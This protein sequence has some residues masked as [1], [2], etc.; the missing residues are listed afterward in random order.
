[1]SSEPLDFL[2]GDSMMAQAI[3]DQDWAMS[4][5][6]AADG[7]PDTLKTT[8]GLMLGSGF[9][10]AVVW[11][12]DLVTLYNDAFIPILGDKPAALGRSFQ[13]IWREAWTDI[14]PIAE[15]AFAGR[16]TYIE[17][18]PLVVERGRGPSQAYFTFC[19]SPVR[20]HQG[21]VLGFL[22][23]VTETTAT[24]IS[25]RRL[26]FLDQLS[27]NLADADDADT[28]MESTTRLLAEHLGVSNC[29]YADM[30]ADQDGFTIRGDWAAPG[31]PTIVG[32][33][34]LADFGR[35]AVK[36]LSAGEPLVIND[37][38]AELA[39]HE[40]ATFQ[41]IGIAATIC[42]P[43]VK[44]GR[45]TALMAI[46]DRKPRVWS[47]YECGLIAEVAQ[48]SWAHIER[49]R[50]AAQLRGSADALRDLNTNLEQRVSQEVAERSRAEEHLRHTQKLDAVGQLTGGIA[51]D[52]NNLLTVIRSSADLLRKPDLAERRR[53]RYLDAISDTADRA[54]KLT[55]HLLAFSRR[56]PL[57]PKVFNACERVAMVAEMLESM[58]GSRIDLVVLPDACPLYVEADPTE[59]EAALLNVAI[60]ARDAMD[61]E[62]R[63][64]IETLA[65]DRLPQIRGHAA[66]DGAFVAVRVTDTGPGVTP[67]VLEHIF[68]PFFTT[69]DVG[70]GTGLGLSQVFGFAKQS[71]GEIEVSNSPAGGAIFTLYLPRAEADREPEVAMTPSLQGPRRGRVLLVEDNAQIGEFTT[72]LLQDL[73]YETEFAPNAGAALERLSADV[74]FDVV[75]S[76]V[77]MPGIDGIE[78]AR[79]IQAQWPQLRI[80]LTS[81]YSHVLAQDAHH[82]FDLLRKPYS[83]VELSSALQRVLAPASPPVGLTS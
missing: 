51:H 35:L 17:D 67:D 58:L 9:P 62:G 7:W 63:L 69:K 19:Y 24:V 75:F 72:Q 79:R 34:S 32:R 59:F 38:L 13:D 65:V 45:L 27:A 83:S 53:Q 8:V 40:A 2:Q 41:A 30:D 57:S 78:L 12:P 5:L 71:G 22:D 42:M 50:S 55:S 39:P 46:H 20:D 52:F 70:R 47:D 49:I 21:R 37:N 26:R 76:D 4:P 31:S 44:A 74:G 6:G 61:G 18:F 77:V 29:A 43:L 11:G 80:L 23:T 66:A 56:Q 28:I 14:G 81:G 68:E 73:G 48:R 16:A 54:A 33:Y 1:M 3:R 36:N 82:G 60:N 25:T 10:Q 15:A 64:T